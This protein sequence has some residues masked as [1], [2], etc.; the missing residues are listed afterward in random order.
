MGNNNIYTYINKK[1]RSYQRGGNL[2]VWLPEAQ[3]V[4]LKGG[5][6]MRQMEPS[7]RRGMRTRGLEEANPSS[8][9]PSSPPRPPRPPPP[10]PPL[11]SPPPPNWS[12]SQQ[13]EPSPLEEEE[14]KEKP[15]QPLISI[16]CTRSAPKKKINPTQKPRK[17]MMR[18][19]LGSQSPSRLYLVL[20]LQ[21][22]HPPPSPSQT[23]ERGGV[24]IKTS[25]MGLALCVVEFIYAS[26]E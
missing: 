12:S 7:D 18:N 22:S 23:Q 5:G 15:S 24:Q 2:S 13:Q 9:L 25:I 10:P 6:S 21:S 16:T 4:C 3:G 26:T 8:T 14:D 17:G 19:S 1:R 20:K 11:P